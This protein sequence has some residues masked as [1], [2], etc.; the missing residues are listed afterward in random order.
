VFDLTKRAQAKFSTFRDSLAFAFA[1]PAV[2]ELGNATGFDFYMQDQAGL[3]HDALMN[4][5]NQFLALAA[6]SPALQ[7]VRPNGLNDEPQYVLEIDDEARAL[8]LSLADIN[9]TVSIAWGSSYVN[10]FI[11]RGRVK[12]CTCRVGRTRACRRRTS[13]SGS[14]ATTRATWCRSRVRHGQVGLDRR[15]CS[16][17]TACRRWKSSASRRRQELG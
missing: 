13:T 8:G 5:R 4:A 10:D 7:R 2:Q 16:A 17:T 9:S 6:K 15:S 1:P 12:R 3:G 14:C 11:D